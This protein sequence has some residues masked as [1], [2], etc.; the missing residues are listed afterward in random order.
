MRLFAGAAL[1]ALIAI[2]LPTASSASGTPCLVG[3]ADKT[4]AVWLEKTGEQPV[5]SLRIATGDKPADGMLAMT[6]E[7]K[8][9]ILVEADGMTCI[10][11]VG[12][13]VPI[14]LRETK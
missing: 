2:G 1:A 10:L 7:G 3:K 8:F 6:P 11:A 14:D 13:A 5:M 9:A 12:E 4:L